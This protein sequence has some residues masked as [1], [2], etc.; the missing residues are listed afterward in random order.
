VRKVM[1]VKYS[2][3]FVIMPGG[4]GTLDELFESVTLIQT[5]KIQPF[6]VILVNRS[7]WAPLLGWIEGTLMAQGLIS[8]CDRE[9]LKLADTAEDVLA[10]LKNHHIPEQAL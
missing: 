2:R 4:F 3:A 10:I 5:H 9:I 7:F 1:F 8:D 6:P